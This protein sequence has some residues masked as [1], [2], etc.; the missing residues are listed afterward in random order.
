[1]NDQKKAEGKAFLQQEQQ[2]EPPNLE[3]N[4][5]RLGGSQSKRWAGPWGGR[6]SPKGG[7]GT[8]F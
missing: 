3:M 4:L 7:I 5:R 8:L 6:S 2:I 1:M